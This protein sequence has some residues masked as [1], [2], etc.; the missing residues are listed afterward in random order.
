MSSGK[1][2]SSETPSF[3]WGALQFR[4]EEVLFSVGWKCACTHLIILYRRRRFVLSESF[5][6]GDQCG[7]YRDVS[8]VKNAEIGL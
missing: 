6:R 5:R 1:L 7:V 2:R 8:E 4:S 3:P